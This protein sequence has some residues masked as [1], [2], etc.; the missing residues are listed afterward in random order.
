[1]DQSALNM[2]HQQ[3]RRAEAHLRHARFMEAIE[4][5]QLAANHLFDALQCTQNPQSVDSI[6]LQRDY[7]LRRKEIILAK[8]EQFENYKKAIENQRNRITFCGSDFEVTNDNQSTSLQVAIYRTMEEA[9]SLLGQLFKRSSGDTLDSSNPS[10]QPILGSKHPKHENTVIEELRTLNEQL[11]SLVY[12]L[13]T[14]LDASTTEVDMLKAKIQKLE[15]KQ[16]TAQT[17]TSATN[18]LKVI[19]DSSGG[20]SPYV[21]SPCSEFSPDVNDQRSSLPPLAPLEMPAFD[22]NSFVKNNTYPR[23][24]YQ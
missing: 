10:S 12:K 1:M 24:E 21:F 6:N 18:S 3:Q 22:F 7:H 11:H 23:H 20:T 13:V 8:K 16:Q 2:A 15:A 17:K 14:Q 4:C 5:H 9:D 19:T